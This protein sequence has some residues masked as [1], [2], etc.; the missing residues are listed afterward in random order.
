MISVRNIFFSFVCKDVNVV[1]LMML[2]FCNFGI[3]NCNKI[4]FCGCNIFVVVRGFI[5]LL[6]MDEV[7]LENCNCRFDL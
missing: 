1:E 2:S 5:V 4:F 7:C 6:N 3:D